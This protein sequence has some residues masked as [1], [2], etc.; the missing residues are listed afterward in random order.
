MRWFRSVN[1]ASAAVRK[2]GTTGTATPDEI[3]RIAAR[4]GQS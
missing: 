1:A 2:L 3:R 4:A